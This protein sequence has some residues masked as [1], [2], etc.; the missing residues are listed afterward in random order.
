MTEQFLVWLDAEFSLL[1]LLANAF[2]QKVFCFSNNDM[3]M[4]MVVCYAM[5]RMKRIICI[6]M[7]ENWLAS[8]ALNASRIPDVK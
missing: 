6:G 5:M 3:V 8:H 1:C 2:L 7:I 4:P